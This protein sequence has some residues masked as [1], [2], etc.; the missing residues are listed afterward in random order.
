VETVE[1]GRNFKEPPPELVGNKE[2][3]EVEKSLDSRKKCN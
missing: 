1:H 2:E 3:Y